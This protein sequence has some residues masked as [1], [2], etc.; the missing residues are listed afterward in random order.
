MMECI[1][2]LLNHMKFYPIPYT[3]EIGIDGRI[4]NKE[5]GFSTDPN[6]DGLIKHSLKP[7]S[8]P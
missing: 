5:R 4:K 7:N 2:F 8:V 1:F 6:G 3:N